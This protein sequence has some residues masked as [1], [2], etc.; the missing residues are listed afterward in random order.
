MKPSE[1]LPAA[2]N[3]EFTRDTIPAKVTAAACVPDVVVELPL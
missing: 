1:G 2:I 3:I